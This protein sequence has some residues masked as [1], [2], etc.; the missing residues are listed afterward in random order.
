MQASQ[1]LLRQTRFR[2]GQTLY[3]KLNG[4]DCT[5]RVGHQA[6]DL[7]IDADDTC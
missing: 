1:P 6:I 2:V 7:F 4:R 3:D 5:R